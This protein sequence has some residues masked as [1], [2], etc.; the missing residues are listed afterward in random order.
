MDIQTPL[1]FWNYETL[2]NAMLDF[3]NC[4]IRQQE[5]IMGSWFDVE[6]SLDTDWSET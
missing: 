3:S 5:P 6:R 4:C 1:L 2:L